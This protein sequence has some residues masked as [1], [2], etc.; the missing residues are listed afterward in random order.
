[1]L[2]P[3]R[4]RLLPKFCL[5]QLRACSFDMLGL[6]NLQTAYRFIDDLKTRPQTSRKSRLVTIRYLAY[7]NGRAI[8]SR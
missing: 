6:S 8:R 1:M 5:P 7:P 3:I 4:L 2:N